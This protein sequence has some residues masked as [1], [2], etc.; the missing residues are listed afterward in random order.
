MSEKNNGVSEFA[1]KQSL[2]E[3]E[4]QAANCLAKIYEKLD[5]LIAVGEPVSINQ[6]SMIQD[7]I[8]VL[9]HEFPKV[10]DEIN[11]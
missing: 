5:I 9:K 1:R 8:I 11:L 2:E 4:C 3:F 7:S 6:I 10:L